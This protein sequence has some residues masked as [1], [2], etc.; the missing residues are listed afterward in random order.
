MTHKYPQWFSNTCAR[1]PSLAPTGS[2]SSS[3]SENLG[4][5]DDEDEEDGTSGY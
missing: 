5:E 1:T 2:G 4:H 3:K